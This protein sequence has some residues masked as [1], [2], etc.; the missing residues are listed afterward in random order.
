MP[1][2][3]VVQQLAFARDLAQIQQ[4]V[5]SAARELTGADGATFVLREA[6]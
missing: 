1:L 2:I 4:I 6:D 5:R 3:S